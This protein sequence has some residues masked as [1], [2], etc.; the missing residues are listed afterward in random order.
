[1]LYIEKT[2]LKKQSSI[3][4]RKFAPITHLYDIIK[5]GVYASSLD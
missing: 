2:N 4:L 3:E 1:M 5:Y